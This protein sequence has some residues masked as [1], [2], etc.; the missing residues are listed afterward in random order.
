MNLDEFLE[1]H[2]LPSRFRATVG[3][4][5]IPVARWVDERVGTAGERAF[6]L[7]INGAQG[8]GKST[9]AHFLGD[10][11][12][13]ECGRGVAGLSIDDIYLTRAER[14]QLGQAVHPL[15][16]TRGVPGTHDVQLGMWVIERLATL[17]PGERVAVPRFDKAVDDRK[18]EDE[19]P[20]VEGPIDVVIFEG[21]CLGSVAAGAAEL[22]EPINA[23]E[24]EEDPD[25]TWRR[26][27]NAQLEAVYP[28]LFDELDALVF[29]AAP[30]FDAVYRWRLE[31]ERK[32]AAIAGADATHVMDE[33]GVARFIQ[34]YE[35]IT[36]RNLDDLPTR[37]DA[38]LSLG[39]DHA[40]TA[41]RFAPDT[42]QRRR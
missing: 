17:G 31:Q 38:V 12:R 26:Y 29:L 22:A 41:L 16:V 11:L 21:W 3:E 28:A 37:A 32:L 18:A 1:R 8:T 13:D 42:D 15:F 35:R 14:E 20:V 2:R 36:R 4:Y 24:A 30:D 6:V 5:Y 25:G 34:H 10:Y 23:L 40:V 7:G 19:W 39:R 33:A 9:L 27:V